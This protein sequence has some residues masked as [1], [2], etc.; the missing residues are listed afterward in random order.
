MELRAA[1]RYRQTA[2]ALALVK[3]IALGDDI[4]Q[5]RHALLRQGAQNE[6]GCYSV[7]NN[8]YRYAI[9]ERLIAPGFEDDGTRHTLL[10]RLAADIGF[11]PS[12]FSAGVCSDESSNRVTSKYFN[13]SYVL[14]NGSW[15][16][17]TFSGRVIG[18][19]EFLLH[20]IIRPGYSVHPVSITTLGGGLGITARVTAEASRSDVERATN[21]NLRCLVSREDCYLCRVMPDAWRDGKFTVEWD[22][23]HELNP[24]EVEQAK[25]Y[26]EG[27]GPHPDENY[28]R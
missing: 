12:S 25:R 8:N 7:R 11:R 15:R 2:A 18:D 17:A 9:L 16:D 27:H 3:K 26:C 5:W 20:R 22:A 19:K 10:L 4:Q 24:T 1:Y 23:N 6:A 21:I 28:R 13:V 14:R